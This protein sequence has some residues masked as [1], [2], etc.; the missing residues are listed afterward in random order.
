[1]YYLAEPDKVDVDDG[2]DWQYALPARP[3]HGKVRNY[4]FFD[5]HVQAIAVGPTGLV[6]PNPYTQ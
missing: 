3:V 2:C 4:L 5:N 1:M 6:A